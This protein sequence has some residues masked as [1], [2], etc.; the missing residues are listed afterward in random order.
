MNNDKTMLELIYQELMAL[1]Q[2]I[3]YIKGRQD[4]MEDRICKKLDSMPNVQHHMTLP[5]FDHRV[6]KIDFSTAVC[7]K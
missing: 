2:E 1:R 6:D 5:T 7:K 3:A 4:G